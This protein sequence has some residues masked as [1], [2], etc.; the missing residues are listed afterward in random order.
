MQPAKPDY[1]IIAR[2]LENDFE[3]VDEILADNPHAINSQR[4]RTGITALMA[5]AGGG[6]SAMVDH[7]LSKPGIDTEI[8]DGFGKTAMEHGRHFPNIV[9]SIMSSRH[10]NMKWKEPRLGP[11]PD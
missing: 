1:D 5:A 6:L 7:L 11:V 3:G 4:P 8:R 9:G 2:A 10:P